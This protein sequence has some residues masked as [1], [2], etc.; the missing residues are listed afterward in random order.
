MNIRTES[1]IKELNNIFSLLNLDYQN[2]N[3]NNRFSFL[4]AKEQIIRGKVMVEYTEINTFLDMCLYFYFFP[5]KTKISNKEHYERIKR[6]KRVNNFDN[7]LLR[8]LKLIR[9]IELLSKI[10]KIPKSIAE[11]IKKINKLRNILAHAPRV[12]F[13]TKKPIYKG[14]NI[15]TLE[16]LKLFLNDSDRIQ[17]FIINCHYTISKYWRR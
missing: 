9:K 2:F 15:F 3:K 13:D 17:H 16:G 10:I 12:V 1:R 4:F 11:D 7:Y 5:K 14:K 8:E 6:S